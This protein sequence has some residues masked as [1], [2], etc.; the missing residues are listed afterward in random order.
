[1]A[2]QVKCSCCLD[3]TASNF[4]L[5]DLS[6]R[7]RQLVFLWACGVDIT[8]YLDDKSVNV[9]SPEDQDVDDLLSS[10]W[11][12]WFSLELRKSGR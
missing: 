1:M 8:E 5:S 10:K 6:Q 12:P 7:E 3:K 4:Y 2:L 9:Y 11:V